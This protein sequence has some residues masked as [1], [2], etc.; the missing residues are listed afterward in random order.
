VGL[1]FVLAILIVVTA[2]AGSY[3]GP[4]LGYF[5]AGVICLVLIL[6]ILYRVF[7]GGPKGK[8]IA[9]RPEAEGPADSR[10]QNPK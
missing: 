9:V 2:L 4:G 10:R 1:V 7:A 6:V 8:G 3:I 5:G